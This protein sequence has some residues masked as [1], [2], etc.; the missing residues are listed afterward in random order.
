MKDLTNS[1]NQVS[2]RRFVGLTATA[3]AFSVLPGNFIIGSSVK[4][5][6]NKPDSKFGGVQV[7]AI[8]YSWRS[9]PGSA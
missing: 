9:M 6:G 2:R 3:A 7:G 4:Q 1:K 8:T 5:S